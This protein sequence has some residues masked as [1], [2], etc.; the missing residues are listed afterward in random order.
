[1][2]TEISYE[3]LIDGESNYEKEIIKKA[4]EKMANK[5]MI[6]QDMSLE[7]AII[8]AGQNSE[9]FVREFKALNKN[10]L[11]FN[12]FAALLGPIYFMY[13]KMYLSSVLFILLS[14]VIEDIPFLNILYMLLMGIAANYIYYN[15]ASYE[16]RTI[17]EKYKNNNTVRKEILRQTGGVNIALPMICVSLLVISLMFLMSMLF[18]AVLH[19]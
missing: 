15:K 14:L 9:S 8:Y 3:E 4:K 12:I 2:K 13:R 7:D 1:M 19:I 18:I 10:K 16:I 17:N 5:E 6:T 11:T